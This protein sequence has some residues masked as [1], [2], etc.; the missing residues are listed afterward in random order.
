VRTKLKGAADWVEGASMRLA[1]AG[2]GWLLWPI[3]F[4][5]ATA[6]ALWS[7]RHPDRLS[8]ID[9]NKLAEPER[10]QGL[11]YLGATFG[12][13][14]LVYLIANIVVRVR[15]GAFRVIETTSA[16]SRKLR[17]LLAMPFIAALRLPGIEK[18]SPKQT[19][20]FAAVSAG[21]FVWSFYHFMRTPVLGPLDAADV[22][23]EIE[24]P[25]ALRR[26][27]NA[28]PRY[29]APAVVAGLWAAYG[30]IFTR[31][32]ITNHHA[33]NSRTTDLGYYDN[34]FYQSIH[35][36]PL[37]CSWIKAGWHGSAHFDPLLVVLSPLYLIYPRAELILALQ[38]F[39]LGAGVVPLYLLAR[40]KDLGRGAALLIAAAYALYPALHGANMYE[41]HSLSLISPLVLWLLYFLET[42]APKR[43]VL[44]LVALLLV[45]EDVALLMCFVGL[46]AILT[47]RPQGVRLGQLTIIMSLVYFVI[48]KRWF[49]E[50]SEILNSGDNEAY[51]FTYYYDAMIPNKSG[52]A[53][54]IVTLLTN[55]GFTLKHILEDAKV[56]FLL[57]LFVPLLFLPFFARTGRVMLIYGLTFCLLASRPAVFVIHFQYSSLIFA[58]AF[59]LVPIAL[60]QIETGSTAPA[61]GLDG[62]RLTRALAGGVFVATL[63]LTWKFG[64][65]VNNQSFRG[66]FTRITRSLSDEQQA[67]YA[68]VNEQATKIPRGA[69]VAATGKM[70]PHISNRRHAYFY[71]EKQRT[72]YVFIDEAE[73]RGNDLERHK[74]AVGKGELIEL[75]R[76]GTMVLFKRK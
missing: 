2:I 31:L 62:R 15:A 5:I 19:V 69:S 18:D 60:R 14:L 75:S 23:D 74:K 58:V 54:L 37:G 51:S 67:T 68:W 64:G 9:T 29:L 25:S 35:G 7:F 41:F 76:R 24:R 26:A 63:L 33:L 46:Y 52:G 22:S 73:L 53:G 66:G 27:L 44:T 11:Y 13:L 16:V 36:R 8:I 45:R 30:F 55:P 71:P 21:L 12:G 59:A 28:V 72:D 4:S 6:A 42:G 40:A 32:S 49:M 43:Y 10:I 50:S 70:G 17:F 3:L 1:T 39:W 48:T 38:S 57:M 47:R 20:F 56:H 65:L 34:I 61:L